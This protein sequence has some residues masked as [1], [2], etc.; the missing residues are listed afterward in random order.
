MG[1][2]SRLYELANPFVEFQTPPGPDEQLANDGE[3]RCHPADARL[4]PVVQEDLRPMDSECLPVDLSLKA[5]AIHSAA[6]RCVQIT[7]V[8]RAVTRNDIVLVE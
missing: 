5:L 1:F 7:A 3:E 6:L 8:Q 2:R 4:F